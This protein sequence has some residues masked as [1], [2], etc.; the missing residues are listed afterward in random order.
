MFMMS[1]LLHFA[2]WSCIVQPEESLVV[3]VRRYVSP[4]QFGHDHSCRIVKPMSSVC[5]QQ[6][7]YIKFFHE[8]GWHQ[9]VWLD[10]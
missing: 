9:R 6:N 7:G 4:C 1:S 2:G 3:I 8:L 10:A 5:I